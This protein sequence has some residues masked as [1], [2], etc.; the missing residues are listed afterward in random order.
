M[1][2]DLP[3]RKDLS[4][5]QVENG[6]ERGKGEE[7]RTNGILAD[8]GLSQGGDRGGGEKTRVKTSLRYMHIHSSMIHN[9]RKVKTTQMSIH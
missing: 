1:T 9:S 7:V 4:G 6:L 2:S 3:F 8:C 5:G